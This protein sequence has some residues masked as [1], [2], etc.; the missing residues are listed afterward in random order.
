MS[1]HYS[2]VPDR[3][4]SRNPQVSTEL[5]ALILSLL[6]KRPTDRPASGGV[7]AQTLR[8]E[9]AASERHD[10]ARVQPSR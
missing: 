9:A 5:E 10:A 2:A 8:Q 1:Q 7:V 4:R 3:P 6:A